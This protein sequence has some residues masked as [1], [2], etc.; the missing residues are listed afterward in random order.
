[1][2]NRRKAKVRISTPTT[3]KAADSVGVA[4]PKMIRP[5]TMKTTSAIGVMLMSASLKP[6]RHGT[7]STS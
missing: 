1:M 5:I 2:L 6:S 3:P 7:S 4:M